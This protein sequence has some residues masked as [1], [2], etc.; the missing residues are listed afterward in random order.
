MV[1]EKYIKLRLMYRLCCYIQS[2][3]KVGVQRVLY[4]ILHT[5]YLL[6]AHSVCYKISLNLRVWNFGQTQLNRHVFYV[7][8]FRYTLFSG[9]V[10][11]RSDFIL[12][13]GV[14]D[15]MWNSRAHSHFQRTIINNKSTCLKAVVTGEYMLER[16]FTGR[17]CFMT[18]CMIK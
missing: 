11:K 4:Y 12:P 15:G 16:I 9:T 6:L 7:S 18:L 3:P 17:E 10:F 5:V 13:L 8:T 1:G 2:R 14:S